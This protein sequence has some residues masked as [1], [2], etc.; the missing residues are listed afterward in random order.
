MPAV[1]KVKYNFHSLTRIAPI[2]VFILSLLYLIGPINS[3]SDFS[4]D[5]MSIVLMMMTVC[6]IL[7]KLSS[8][9][10]D[11]NI[12]RKRRLALEI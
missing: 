11:T 10:F 5:N 8:Q 2:F 7:E 4:L 6:F 9:F 3:F 1:C 12:F